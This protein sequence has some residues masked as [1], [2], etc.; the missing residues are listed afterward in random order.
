MAVLHF[1][2]LADPGSRIIGEA[3]TTSSN[4]IGMLESGLSI[5]RYI[6]CRRVI[7]LYLTSQNRPVVLSAVVL[8]EIA[9][10]DTLGTPPVMS[11][12]GS[13]D[14]LWGSSKSEST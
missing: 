10:C 2:S 14:I 12:N 5:H 9:M 8:T 6:I 13:F 1:G 4:T 7:L 3:G 11:Q